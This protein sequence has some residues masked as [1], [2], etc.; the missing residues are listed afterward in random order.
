MRVSSLPRDSISTMSGRKDYVQVV[1]YFYFFNPRWPPH[2][3]IQD[4]GYV[5]NWYLEDFTDLL[6]PLNFDQLTAEKG[7]LWY[8]GPVTE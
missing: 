5:N 6:G 1:F 7:V 3:V 8:R 2:R 4:G